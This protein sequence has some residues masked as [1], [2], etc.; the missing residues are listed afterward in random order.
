[1]PSQPASTPL[2]PDDLADLDALAEEL[3]RLGFPSLRLTPPS[4]PPYVDAGLPG[5]MAPGERISSRAGAFF[6]RR[7]AGPIASSGQPH[8]AAAI[9]SDALR[10]GTP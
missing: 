6:W 1:M 9:I 7:T 10:L 8:I 3:N 4:Q 5:G 2:G